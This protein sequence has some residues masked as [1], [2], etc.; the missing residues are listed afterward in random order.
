MSSEPSGVPDYLIEASTV[1]T[2]V[3]LDVL[4]DI[5]TCYLKSKLQGFHL[6]G[7]NRPGF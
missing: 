6:T 2:L 4:P 7:V 1:D 5:V 3:A